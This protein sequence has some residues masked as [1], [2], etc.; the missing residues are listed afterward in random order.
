M[1]TL[2]REFVTSGNRVDLLLAKAE[3]DFLRQIPDGVNVINFD[4]SRVLFC[5]FSLARY[6]RSAR[7]AAILSAMAHA[8]VVAVLAKAISG[9]K[10]RL[11]LSEHTL[12]KYL[13]YAEKRRVSLLPFFQRLFYPLAYKVIAVSNS[14]KSDLISRIGLSRNSIEVINNPIRVEDI[15]TLAEED[16]HPWLKDQDIP[17][18]IGV[19]RLTRA[20]GFGVLINA[21][22]IVAKDRELR[23]II[24][25]EGEGR[26]RLAKLIEEKELQDLVDMPGFVENPMTFFNCA[27]LFVLSSEYEG[28][29]NVLV[30]AL[31]CGTP[32]V[33]TDCPGGPAEILEGGKYGI[34]VPVGDA[35]AMATAIA[36]SI[37]EV[38][39]PDALRSRASD[40]SAGKIAKK[41]E[42]IL[43]G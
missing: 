15:D 27:S 6:I 36:R 3:G 11:V 37:D 30:E 43:L 35:E 7:P 31:A 2:A 5:V 14:V 12:S 41:Y 9:A 8:N 28:F 40:F 1:L 17:V 18:V 13:D 29:G 25:G 26:E 38:T 42:E 4:K 32:V 34:L 39:D 16:V 33:S 10:T 20:K 19:G 22:D 23:L 24:L 21:F